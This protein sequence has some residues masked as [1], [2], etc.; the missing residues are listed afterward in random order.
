MALNKAQIIGQLTDQVINLEDPTLSGYSPIPCA[1][2][3]KD[4]H[5]QPAEL[6]NWLA[7]SISNPSDPTAIY[8]GMGA[9]GDV[10]IV[11]LNAD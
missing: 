10:Y 9:T 3:V 1:A 4:L 6:S 11:A 8:A 5:M 2:W 7:D